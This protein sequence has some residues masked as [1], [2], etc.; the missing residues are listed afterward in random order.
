[1]REQAS[2]IQAEVGRLASDVGRLDERVQKLQRHFD[3]ASDDV[4]QIRIS[5][6]KVVRQ[7]TRI[8]EVEMREEHSGKIASEAR[9]SPRTITKG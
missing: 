7:T 1:M 3:L 6:E 5:A 4:R 9:Q 8:E 2:L